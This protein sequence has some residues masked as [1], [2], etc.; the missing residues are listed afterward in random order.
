MVSMRSDLKHEKAVF[1]GWNKGEIIMPL[2]TKYVCR[3]EI[4]SCFHARA[5]IFVRECHQYFEDKKTIQNTRKCRKF[6]IGLREA[7][8]Q[9]VN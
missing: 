8:N 7:R 4:L 5:P 2:F 3:Q 1:S 6:A 9:K